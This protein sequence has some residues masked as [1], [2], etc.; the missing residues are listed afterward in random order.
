[1]ARLIVEAE[2]TGGTGA[3]SGIAKPGNQLPLYIVV[4]VTHGNGAPRI[5]MSGTDFRVESIIVAPGGGYVTIAQVAELQ[6]GVYL[7]EVVP[8][9][10]ATWQLGRNIFWVAVTYGA[11]Q[12]QTVCSVFVD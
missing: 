9:T 8:I 11:G 2:A 6:P 1:M 7:V 12:G 5:G 4:S 3:S 10:N